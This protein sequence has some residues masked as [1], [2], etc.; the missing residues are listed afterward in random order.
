MFDKAASWDGT[1]TLVCEPNQTLV[2]DGKTA[3]LTTTVIEARANC[4]LILRNCRLAGSHAVRGGTNVEIVVENS[5]L[6]GSI[7]AVEA[8]MN[9]SL[10]LRDQSRLVGGNSAVRLG[11]NASVEVHDS[12]LESQATALAAGFNSK[13]DFRRAK[14]TGQ[15]ALDLG[16]N[17]SG[18][19][20]ES[21]MS[22]DRQ[23]GPSARIEE[24]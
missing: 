20:S 17:A 22:G 4:Q 14:I 13:L 12:A 7:A 6:E 11:H 10:R 5:T 2:L 1:S 15:V 9:V 18:T 8:D 16:A 3:K 23:L 19:I 21:T 24:R